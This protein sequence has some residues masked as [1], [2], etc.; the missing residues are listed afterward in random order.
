VD[1]G[2]IEQERFFAERAQANI[3]M[4]DSSRWGPVSLDSFAH[5]RD[6]N[7]IITNSDAPEDLAAA[8]REQVIEVILC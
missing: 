3:G 7:T 1:G 8:A 4:I 5:T 2:L 6:I